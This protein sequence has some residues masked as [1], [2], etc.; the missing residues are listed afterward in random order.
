MSRARRRARRAS[1]S[2][3]W[4]TGGVRMLIRDVF[5]ITVGTTLYCASRVY[6]ALRRRGL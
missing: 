2:W 4:P 6:Q 3:L 1:D 5:V